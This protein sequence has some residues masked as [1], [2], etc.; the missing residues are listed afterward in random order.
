MSESVARLYTEARG[1]FAV[2]ERAAAA[3]LRLALERLTVEL[4]DDVG[5]LHQ[6]IDR[7]VANRGL[8]VIVQQT[9]DAVRVIG[10]NAVHA[11]EI[12]MEEMPGAAQALFGALN[13]IVERLVTQEKQMR[14]IIAG[15]PESERNKITG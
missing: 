11:G 7:L 5:P 9:L 15:L 2:S 3:L 1:V 6:R 4:G 10:N 14:G 8:P 13:F 12:Q